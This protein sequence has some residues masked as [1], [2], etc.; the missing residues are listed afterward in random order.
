[1][2]ASGPSRRRNRCIN[3]NC[4]ATI[5]TSL[6]M[7]SLRRQVRSCQRLTLVGERPKSA[8]RGHSTPEQLAAVANGPAAASA[9][10]GGRTDRRSKRTTLTSDDRTDP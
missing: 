3:T 5:G 9:R 6:T 7:S 2:M 4:N 1:L 10:H 8:H